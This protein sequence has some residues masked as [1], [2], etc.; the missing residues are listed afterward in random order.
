MNVKN[1]N[2]NKSVTVQTAFI[3]YIISYIV[4]WYLGDF[5]SNILNYFIALIPA[6][7]AYFFIVYYSLNNKSAQQKN[8]V[9]L[10]IIGIIVRI[11]LI[12]QQPFLSDDVYRYLWDGKV[13]FSGFN[14]FSYPPNSVA[15]QN[16]QDTNIYPYINFKGIPTV[17]PPLSQLVFLMSYII[18]YNIIVWKII[19][20]LFESILVFFLYKLILHFKVNLMRLSIYLLNPLAVI[21][22]HGSGHLEI[23]AI[24]FLIIGIY[25]F[26]KNKTAT[27]IFMFVLSI[28][29]KYNPLFMILPLIK[30]RFLLKFSIILFSVVVVLLPFALNGTVPTAGMISYSN[31]WEFNGFFYKIFIF[32]YEITGFEIQKWFTIAYNGRMEDFYLSGALYYRFFAIVVFLVIVIDQIKKLKL[33]ENFKGVNYL[34]P[35]LFIGYSML[36]LSPT[37]Y[38]WYLIW[39][40]PLLIFIPNW[41]WLFFTFLIQLSYYVL[42]QYILDGV[43]E[44][45][46]L[47][48]LLQYIPFYVLLLFEY[49]DN[50]KIKGWFVS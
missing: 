40:I 41:S 1:Q 43:W 12:P 22:T 21:E 39:V 2:L 11:I 35:V 32:L 27:S 37:L 10:I 28:L 17:Y 25:Y 45:S 24:M 47:I 18:G 20:L 26:Y 23:I 46:T 50:R 15:L 31:R 14:P 4:L 34:K 6:Y 16:L 30:K 38:P 36:L 48:L 42:Q 7:V 33:T 5:R 8:F 3:L 44:E 13:S 49:L 29:S 9:F 19:L